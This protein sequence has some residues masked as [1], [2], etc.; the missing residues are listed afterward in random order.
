MYKRITGIIIRLTIEVVTFLNEDSS[1]SSIEDIFNS[2]KIDMV[3]WEQ[4]MFLPEMDKNS[5]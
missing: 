5:S 4:E 1:L 3:Q 2:V